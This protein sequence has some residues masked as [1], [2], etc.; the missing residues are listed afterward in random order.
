MKDYFALMGIPR[1]PAVDEETVKE[2]YFRLAATWHPDAEQGETEKFRQLQEA[3][4]TLKEPVA[5]LRHLAELESGPTEESSRPAEQMDLFLAVGAVVQEAK[6]F[7][8]RREG[9]RSALAKAVMGE[10]GR[11]IRQ[12]VLNVQTQ[13]ETTLAGLQSELKIIDQRWPE[14]SSAELKN[15]ASTWR[16][17]ARW[18]NE[19]ATAEFAL[20]VGA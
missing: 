13:V 12:R 18:Q 14:V 16:Y 5:R 11:E 15:L 20:M 7:Q 6:A 2:A 1:R 3:Y 17:L 19:L 10:A 9:A 8:S 4:Q